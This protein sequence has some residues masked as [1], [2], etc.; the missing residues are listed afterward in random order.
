MCGR[1]RRTTAEEE[2][3]RRYNIRR[4]KQ[5]DLPISYNIAPSQKVLT[6]RFNPKTK[7][8]SL[9]ALQWGLIPYWAKDPKFAYKTIDARVETVDTAPSYREAFKKRRCLIPSDGF[10]EWKKVLGG[11]IPYSISMKDDSPSCSPGCGKAGKIPRTI[12]GCIYLHNPNAKHVLNFAVV[13]AKRQPFGWRACGG[14]VKFIRRLL[15][16][17]PIARMR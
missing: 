5:T 6:I 8:R 3:A 10:Y 17:P 14:S 2:L 13:K 15:C 12:S 11:K 16:H 4:P 7:Q 1:Y 9:D